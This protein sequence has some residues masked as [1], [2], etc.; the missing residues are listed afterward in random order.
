ME[1][2][3]LK[4]GAEEVKSLVSVTMLALKDLGAIELYELV[5]VCRNRDH[6][7]WGGTANVL[8][9]FGLLETDGQ[10]HDSIR[11]IVLSAANGDGLD[12]RLGSPVKE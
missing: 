3:I 8:K 5:Q 6:Q 1:T 9:A 12:M 11:N 2:V 7:M 10:P 4:N